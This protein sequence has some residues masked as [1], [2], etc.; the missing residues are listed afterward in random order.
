M[1][2][3]R[4]KK[5]SFGADSLAKKSSRSPRLVGVIHLPALPGSPRA[6]L[7]LRKIVD[8]AVAEAHVLEKLG[9]DA[10]IIENFGDAPFFKSDVPPITVAGMTEVVSEVVS[11]TRVLVGVNVLRNAGSAALAIAHAT[12]ADFIRVNVLSGVYATDQGLIEGCSATLLR[13]RKAMGSSVR[14]W[15]DVLVKHACAL[16]TDE[17]HLAVEETVGRGGAQ[18]VIVTGSSTGRAV[19]LDRLRKVAHAAK[20]F[21]APVYIGSG[22]T[23]ESW[24]SL[25]QFAHG[26]I[27]G[28]AL[29]AKGIAGAPIELAR[30]R[31]ISRAFLKS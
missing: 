20:T 16:S 28:S 17:P 21:K 30:A 15:G 9:F 25:S 27:V 31:E 1:K 10:L 6:E 18:A 22:C 11:V 5:V 4:L 29:R 26:A 23:A 19:D 3:R 13:E 7:T 24:A 14:I 8:R 2:N 12:G